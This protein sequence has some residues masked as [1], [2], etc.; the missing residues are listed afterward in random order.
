MQHITIDAASQNLHELI[1]AAINGEEIIITKDE[2]PMVKLT[3]VILEK[4]RSPLFGSAKDLI[5]ISDD[6]DEP[7]EEFQDYM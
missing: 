3:P 5:T 7:L 6:F 2:Q 4:K 1:A